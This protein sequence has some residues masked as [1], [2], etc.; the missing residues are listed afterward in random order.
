MSDFLGVSL[1]LCVVG[2][3]PRSAHGT[4][5]DWKEPMPVSGHP[6][7][8]GNPVA[9]GVGADVV[10]SPV[11]LGVSYNNIKRMLLLVHWKLT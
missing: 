1:F 10:A 7:T 3:H 2:Q 9:P 4:S 8:L 5:S 6:W 11:I